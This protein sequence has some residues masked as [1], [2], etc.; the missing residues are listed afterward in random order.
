MVTLKLLLG[1]V[2]VKAQICEE[3][4]LCWTI[5]IRINRWNK[6]IF[7]EY[8][9]YKHIG[10]RK[11]R[12]VSLRNIGT[13]SSQFHSSL[14][15][16]TRQCGFSAGNYMNTCAMFNCNVQF[17]HLVPHNLFQCTLLSWLRPLHLRLRVV[18]IPLFFKM[19][20]PWTMNNANKCNF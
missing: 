4:N 9:K 7:V 3:L 17:V 1:R 14:R 13:C 12:Q 11:T 8:N 10:K 2:N 16:Y 20:R 5:K 18:F 15:S 19:G 6:Q